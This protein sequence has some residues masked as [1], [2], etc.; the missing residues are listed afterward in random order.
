MVMGCFL[1][2]VIDIINVL[3]VALDETEISLLK[4]ELERLK[5]QF[6]AFKK[7]FE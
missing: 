4:E 5:D 7:Q 3:G 6:A 2:V 1:S